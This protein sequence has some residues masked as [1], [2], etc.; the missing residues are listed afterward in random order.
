MYKDKGLGRQYW[1]WWD[2]AQKVAYGIPW[3]VDLVKE[4]SGGKVALSVEN[5]RGTN[6]QGTPVVMSLFKGKIS[7]TSGQ[8]NWMGL[9]TLDG[10]GGEQL[11][12]INHAERTSVKITLPV[13][14]T[15]VTAGVIDNQGK[16][17]AI[18]VETKEGNLILQLPER[19]L[20]VVDWR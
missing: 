13:A 18:E 20:A 11:L 4:M 17:E 15:Q 14:T 16:K 5:L 19:S 2:S 1:A 3:M 8:V 12:L 7:S 6:D 9:R 10:V